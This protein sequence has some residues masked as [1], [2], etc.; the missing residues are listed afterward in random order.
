MMKTTHSTARLPRNGPKRPRVN[1]PGSKRFPL[2]SLI[3]MGMPSAST[4]GSEGAHQQKRVIY[5]LIAVRYSMTCSQ[6]HPQGRECTPMWICCSC[7]WYEGKAVFQISDFRGL[8][9]LCVLYAIHATSITMPC[10]GLHS[11]WLEW[12]CDSQLR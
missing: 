10:T 6:L 9:L 1:G 3:S 7:R 2:M 8:S 11:A 12:R 5:I 4:G